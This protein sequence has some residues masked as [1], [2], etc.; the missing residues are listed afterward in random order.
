VATAPRIELPGDKSL[1][2]RALVLAALATG[3]ST[4][5]HPLTGLDAR[6]MATVLRGLGVRISP[7]RGRRICVQGVGLKGLRQPRGSLHC[8]N[9][10]TTA[11]LLLGILAACPFLVRITG[12]AS[13][14]RRP[15]RRVT[16]PL[17]RMGASFRELA[18][19]GL[20]LEVCGG[21]LHAI[22]VATEVASAQVKSAILL[23]GLV[24]G[25]EVAV[26]EP[27]RSRDH[28]ERMLQALEVEV[29]V[30]GT[31]VRLRPVDAIPS[32]EARVPGDPS[33]A[34]FLIAAALLAGRGEVTLGEVALNP[35][36][37]GFLEV[38]R[39]MGAEVRVK[40]ASRFLGEPVG[41]ITVTGADLRGADVAP[42]EVPSLIDEIPVLAV[43]AGASA[44]TTTFRG[45]SELRRKES[46]RLHL[47]ARNL[48]AVGVEARATEDTL[49]VI[50]ASRPPRG[51]VDTGVDHRMAM[52]FAALGR[53]PG[54]AVRLSERESPDV[55]YPHFFRDLE[56]AAPRG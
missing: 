35:T 27:L 8:G 16:T 14:R 9:S 46:D 31:T 19:D 55:S 21:R 13:L 11:R 40:E 20:P 3:D 1:T 44:G 42:D 26:T 36:R 54:A 51:R 12:D 32:F 48:Q 47:L 4:I 50:G 23:A 33:S 56:W 41:E 52:A 22:E 2:L 6:S 43:L 17:E 30:Q 49:R 18:G 7:L 24:A 29:D 38:L 53:M 39:R 37:T 28:T 15:M 45:V 10:G 34:A 5:E 25:V